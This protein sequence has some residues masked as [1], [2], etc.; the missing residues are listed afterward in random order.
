MFSY[1]SGGKG[2]GGV[3]E[4]LIGEGGGDKQWFRKDC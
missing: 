2:G 1:P 3:Q 4:F